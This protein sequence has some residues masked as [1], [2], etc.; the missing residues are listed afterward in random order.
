MNYFYNFF[1][2]F[3]YNLLHITFY[4]FKNKKVLYVCSYGG[5]ASK[6]LVSE[7]SDYF[8]FTYHIHDIN[9][10]KKLKIPLRTKKKSEFSFSKFNCFFPKIYKVIFIVRKPSESRI[11]R[12]SINHCINIGGDVKNYKENLYD[13]VKMNKDTMLYGKHLN[14]YLNEKPRNYDIVIINFHKIFHSDFD[15]R[16]ILEIKAPKKILLNFVKTDKYSK[17]DIE[18]LNKLKELYRN[19]D[20]KVEKL[21]AYLKIKSSIT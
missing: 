7:L 15:F 5:S 19:L 11:S 21:P 9:P 14:N 2:S 3:I 6:Y 1:K 16:K 18:T 13:Y 10:S 12:G 17:I 4:L 8:S 20:E